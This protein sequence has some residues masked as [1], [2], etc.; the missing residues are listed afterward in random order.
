MLG[1]GA[2]GE[3]ALGESGTVSTEAGNF[4]IT[5]HDVGL[6]ANRILDAGCGV[7]TITGQ[8]AFEGRTRPGLS[9]VSGGGVRGLRASSGGGGKGLR[10]RA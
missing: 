3:L 7:F 2:I 5:G 8:A 9:V 1:F 4:V 6:Y 10:I